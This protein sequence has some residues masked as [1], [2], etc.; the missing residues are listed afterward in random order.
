MR[1]RCPHLRTTTLAGKSV[2]LSPFELLDA[3]S[4]LW[5]AENVSYPSFLEVNASQRDM[6]VLPETSIKQPISNRLDFLL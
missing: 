4:G 2:G 6:M 5:L 1:R 3:L